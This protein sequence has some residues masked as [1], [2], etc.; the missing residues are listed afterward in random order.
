MHHNGNGCAVPMGSV[1][2][3][4]IIVSL[5]SGVNLYEVVYKATNFQGVQFHGLMIL[6]IFFMSSFFIHVDVCDHA[7]TQI[8]KHD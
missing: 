8:Y 3:R 5:A 7:I 2:Y 1:L 6:I 4:I